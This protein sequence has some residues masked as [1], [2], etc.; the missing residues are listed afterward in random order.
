MSRLRIHPATWLPKCGRAIEMSD[1]T[2]S[3]TSSSPDSLNL[4]IVKLSS[5]GDVIHTL[6]CLQALRTHFPHAQI[7]WLAEDV[8]ANLLQGHP[9]IDRL[10]EIP[11]KQIRTSP[12]TSFFSSIKPLVKTLRS[13]RYD[14]VIDFQGLTKSGI[15][16]WLSG[17]K[18]RIG[19]KGKD[20][21]E[22]NALFM[23]ERVRSTQNRRHVIEKNLSLLAPLGI[24][25]T[26]EKPLIHIGPEDEAYIGM[27]LREHG[28]P[29][30]VPLIALF[31]G[32]TWE[33]KQWP[34]DHFAVL[35]SLL[36]RNTGA[37]ILILWGPDEQQTGS[38]IHKSMLKK[39][40]PALLA[41]PTTMKQLAAILRHTGMLICPDTG[42]MH[43]AAALDIPVVALFGASDPVRNGP[44]CT[45]QVVVQKQDL[46]CV[47]C[48]KTRCPLKG[49]RRLNCMCSITPEEVLE[50]AR[51]LMG[52]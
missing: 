3:D 1:N 45:R 19:F 43:L 21:R 20:S 34:E 17:A 14:L 11:K 12:F 25:P 30:D 46:D 22:L 28:L 24:E 37:T 36:H 27:F 16:A 29:G 15:A 8:S 52:N 49:N 48:W 10:F 23:T 13:R 18:R 42:P 6:P 5:V 44:Y 35:G 7:D 39:E 4:L 2:G 51:R 32:A 40:V 38:A 33:T 9:Q 41:P 26:Y 31:P 47:P 50:A